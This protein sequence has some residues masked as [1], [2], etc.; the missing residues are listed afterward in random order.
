MSLISPYHPEIDSIWQAISATGARSIAVASALP[1]EGASQIAV[2]LARRAARFAAAET[3]G[4]PGRPAPT[5][6][7]ALLVD[8]DLR[9]P[10][11]LRMLGQTAQPDAIVAVEGM[12]LAVLGNIGPVSAAA[13]RERARLAEQLA[14]W[15]AEWGTVVL[16]AA[17]LLGVER[18]RGQR[19][20]PA[21]R[22]S[23]AE[24]GEIAGITAAAAADVCIL[25][26]L[27][28]GTSGTRI[29]EAREKLAAAGANLI[30][31]ILNDRDNPSLL[32]E[33]DRE[34]YRFAKYFPDWMA[35]LRARMHRS[36]ILTVRV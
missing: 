33:L 32:A 4:Q 24:G 31:T 34:T 27:A 11:A 15:R 10:A 26:A 14:A 18:R 21:D 25:V 29:R 17:P 19:T 5:R 22:R 28:G 12:D 2:A 20:T 3:P 6:P 30:G 36:P 13:W 16:D 1:R 7:K 35:G 9:R 8:L 23:P